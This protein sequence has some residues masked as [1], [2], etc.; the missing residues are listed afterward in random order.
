VLFA[1]RKFSTKSGK[2]N[3]LR[4]ADPVPFAP[5]AERPMLLMA[6]STDRAQASQWLP[7]AQ[8]GPASAVAHPSVANGFRDGDLVRVE[9]ELGSLT[10]RLRLDPRQR[11][12]VLL[13]DKGGWRHAGRCAN[14]I[15]PALLTDAGGGAA[16]YD[17]PVRLLPVES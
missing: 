8:V 1:D 6:I 17:T 11:R 10:V 12:D 3:L 7:G 2:V 5:P 13:M 9:S 14:S 4:S 16:Y 15:A